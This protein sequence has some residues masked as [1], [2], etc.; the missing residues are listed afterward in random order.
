MSDLQAELL[1]SAVA[2]LTAEITAAKAS[3]SPQDA[4]G[5]GDWLERIAR[6]VQIIK[7]IMELFK[8]QP[9]AS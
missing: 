3:G 8:P 1:E 4:P 5:G 9:I 6:I 7:M 2:V